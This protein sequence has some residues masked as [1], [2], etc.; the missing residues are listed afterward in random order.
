MKYDVS[1]YYDN[2]GPDDNNAQ[3]INPL[4]YTVGSETGWAIDAF[5]VNSGFVSVDGTVWKLKKRS[6]EWY[7]IYIDSIDF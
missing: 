7:I 2:N 1:R 5:A 3:L 6:I 4:A